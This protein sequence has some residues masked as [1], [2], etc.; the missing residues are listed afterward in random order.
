MLYMLYKQ[1]ITPTPDMC[2][3]FHISHIKFGRAL[4]SHA[5]NIDFTKYN[6]KNKCAVSIDALHPR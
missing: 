5:T 2:P 3:Y 4:H 6:F 1:V